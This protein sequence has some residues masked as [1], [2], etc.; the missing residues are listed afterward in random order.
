[1]SEGL[2]LWQVVSY[3]KNGSEKLSKPMSYPQA[4]Q[5]WERKNSRSKRRFAVRRAQ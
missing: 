3:M 4:Y 5:M 2:Q 1:M